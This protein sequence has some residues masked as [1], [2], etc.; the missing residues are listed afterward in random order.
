MATHALFESDMNLL[1]RPTAAVAFP[2]AFERS[3]IA[4]SDSFSAPAVEISRAHRRLRRKM[5]REQGCGLEMLGHAVD[6]LNDS[7]FLEGPEEDIIDLLGFSLEAVQLLISAQQRLLE[8]IP[9]VEPFS[10]RLWNRL[11]R[12]RAKR[13]AAH[14]VLLTPGR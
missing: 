9:L 8:S 1:S 7:Y 3:Y 11:H 6:Y 12:R 4:S 2:K 14:V 10:W 13:D 5:T